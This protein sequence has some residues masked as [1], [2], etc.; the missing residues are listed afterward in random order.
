MKPINKIKE[1]MKQ[2]KSIDELIVALGQVN[3]SAC[4]MKQAYQSLK[5]EQGINPDEIWHR[6]FIETSA[7]PANK[8][9]NIINYTVVLIRDDLQEMKIVE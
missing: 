5:K 1:L 2:C 8:W 9:E 7:T 3:F 6:F 4:Y